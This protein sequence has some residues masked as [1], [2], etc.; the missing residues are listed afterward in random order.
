MGE[1]KIIQLALQDG[2]WIIRDIQMEVSLHIRACHTSLDPTLES[3]AKEAT[4]LIEQWHE[5]EISRVGNVLVIN[6]REKEEDFPEITTNVRLE[7]G[8]LSVSK[9]GGIVSYQEFAPGLTYED[10]YETPYG[11]LEMAVKT[12]SMDIN[13]TRDDDGYIQ[14]DYDIYIAGERIGSCQLDIRIRAKAAKSFSHSH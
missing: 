10:H 6:Y 3:D 8:R 4:D 11:I 1:R 13:F 2:N 7:S 5:G 9:D 12:K 14:V